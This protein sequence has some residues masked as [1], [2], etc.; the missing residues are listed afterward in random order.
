MT[1]KLVFLL[2]LKAFLSKLLKTVLVSPFVDLPAQ[3][4]ISSSWKIEPVSEGCPNKPF[5][6]LYPRGI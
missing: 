6:G 4:C 5:V 3:T 2:G 1:F